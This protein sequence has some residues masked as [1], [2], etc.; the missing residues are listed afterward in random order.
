MAE[1]S[2]DWSDPRQAG[3]LPD[4]Y[5]AMGQTAENV[6]QI[7]D[8]SRAEQDEFG[9]PLAEP[10]REGD[11]ERLLGA[12]D[13]PGHVTDGAV[14]DKDDGPRAGVTLEGVV[15]AQAGVSPRRHG[16]RR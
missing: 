4:V 13:H 7:K 11:R 2:F 14:A 1:G 10:R 16:H 6:A 3:D 5:I 12:R 15:V 8:I 9:V